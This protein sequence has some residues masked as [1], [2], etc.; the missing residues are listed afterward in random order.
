MRLDV[1]RILQVAQSLDVL[2]KINDPQYWTMTVGGQPGMP[3]ETVQWRLAN[4]TAVEGTLKVKQGNDTH[5]LVLRQD[6]ARHDDEGVNYDGQEATIP[7]VSLRGTTHGLTQLAI[8]VKASF[9]LGAQ[10]RQYRF[11]CDI[12]WVD[13]GD[14]IHRI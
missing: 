1:L 7:H 2:K 13:L 8:I 11:D 12:P 9:T 5:T 6:L 3:V 4:V 14:L 10:S